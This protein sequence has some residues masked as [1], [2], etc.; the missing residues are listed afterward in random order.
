[1]GLT[2]LFGCGPIRERATERMTSRYGASI[3][4]CWAMPLDLRGLMLFFVL[5][6]VFATLCNGFI[7][8]YMQALFRA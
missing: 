1:M 3:K 7:V 5:L 8:A 4:R 2:V 6:S